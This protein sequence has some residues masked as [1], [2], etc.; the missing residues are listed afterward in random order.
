ML[1]APPQCT[2]RETIATSTSTLSRSIEEDGK[3]PVGSTYCAGLDFVVSWRDRPELARTLGAFTR[4]AQRY[5]GG[6]TIVNYGGDGTQLTDLL[7]NAESAVTVVAV[8]DTPW[9]NKA[10]AQNMGA[11]HSVRE[12]LFFCDGDILFAEDALDELVA[13]VA[14][15]KATFGTVA[16]VTETDLN[17]R[18]AGNV[19]MFGY[20]LRIRLAN[21]R[22]LQIIDNE[23]DVEDGTRQAQGLLLTHRDNFARIDGYNGRL[24]GWGWEDQDMIARLTLGL[25]LQRVERGDA[26]HISHGDDARVRHYPPMKDRW[27][28]RDRMFRQALANYDAGDFGGTFSSDVKEL[29]HMSAVTVHTPT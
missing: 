29:S 20:H 17:S 18:G 8:R 9:F 16:R 27:E 19:V 12:L 26:T 14:E 4:C 11:A 25:G 5:G 7:R 24:H 10:K 15:D 22:T 21:G 3:M 1:H 2:A 13:R 28:S 23:E 6:V